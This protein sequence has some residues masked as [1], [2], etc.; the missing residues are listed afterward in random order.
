[1]KAACRFRQ[2]WPRSR[3][4][5]LR[6]RIQQERDLWE[7]V[8]SRWYPSGPDLELPVLALVPELARKLTLEQVWKSASEQGWIPVAGRGLA[9]PAGV[10][11]PQTSW[12][13][14]R[15]LAFLQTLPN[16]GSS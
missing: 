2:R 8:G 7:G 3:K 6:S 14:T 5:S 1:M 16:L 12:H 13:P 11:L 10:V 15:E 4:W 9:I